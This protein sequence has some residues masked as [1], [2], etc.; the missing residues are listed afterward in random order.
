MAYLGKVRLSDIAPNHPF[1]RPCIILGG[2][3][4]PKSKSPLPA[5]RHGVIVAVKWDDDW[6]AIVVSAARWQRIRRGEKVISRTKYWREGKMTWCH[7]LFDE[8]A[9]R[10]LVMDYRTDDGLGFNGDIRDATLVELGGVET[11]PL[12]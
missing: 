6:H 10:S 9:E 7:W 5:G 11:Y 3:R 1:A 8:K 4:P 12:D 2:L